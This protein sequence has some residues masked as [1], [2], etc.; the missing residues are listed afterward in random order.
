MRAKKTTIDISGLDAAQIGE[1]QKEIHKIAQSKLAPQRAEAPLEPVPDATQSNPDI[2]KPKGE[3]RLKTKRMRKIN[4][5]SFLSHL[6]DD[7]HI[8]VSCLDDMD[9]YVVVPADWSLATK[10]AKVL[11]TYVKAKDELVE[12][13]ENNK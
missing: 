11:A 5:Y 12:F 13:K 10:G 7:K 2:V 3:P 8:R 6:T 4:G 1:L 9:Q